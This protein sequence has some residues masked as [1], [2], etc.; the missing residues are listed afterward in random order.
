MKGPK[1]PFHETESGGASFE[2]LCH[3]V[4]PQHRVKAAEKG[5]ADA[6]VPRHKNHRMR[7]ALILSSI[8]ATAWCAASPAKAIG[9]GMTQTPSLLGQPLDFSAQVRV[10]ADEVLSRECVSAEI[11]AGENRLGS[12]QIRVQVASGRDPNE[13]A[14]RVRTLHALNEPIVTINLTVGCTSRVARQFVAFLDPPLLN[15]ARA[16]DANAPQVEPAIR[17][18]ARG[19]RQ[20]AIASQSSADASA[21][22]TVRQRQRSAE[23]RRNAAAMAA[24]PSPSVRVADGA[25]SM[26]K[27]DAQRPAIARSG[28]TARPTGTAR[29]QLESAA[30]AVV[31]AQAASAV[32]TAAAASQQP[33]VQFE[34]EQL[35]LLLAQEKER[36]RSLEASL[37][38]LR[39]EASEANQKR[40]VVAATAPA[41]AATALAIAAPVARPEPQRAASPMLYP[42]VGFGALLAV[43]VGIAAWRPKKKTATR[44]SRWWDLSQQ[45]PPEKGDAVASRVDS[46]GSE[47]EDLRAQLP[48]RV[49]SA[50]AGS[51]VSELTSLPIGG[52]EVTTVAAQAPRSFSA[53]ADTLPAA[54][55]HQRPEAA[56]PS[57]ELLIDLEQEAEFFTVI[58]QDEAAVGL[59]SKHIQREG[60]ISPLPFLKLLEIHRR[61][62]DAAAHDSVAESFRI[63]FSTPPPASNATG[64]GR[65]LDAYPS[66]LAG[67][68]ALWSSPREV[69]PALEAWLFRR[70][71]SAEILDLAAYRDLLF[72]Y[73]VA[74]DRAD[75]GGS[76]DVELDLVLPLDS[77]IDVHLP[78]A[79]ASQ[80]PE[81]R[82]SRSAPLDFDISV[83]ASLDESELRQ[84][85]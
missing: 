57:M 48:P 79:P 10:S 19:D 40:A 73:A 9:F 34:L 44:T 58:G 17:A 72:L 60:P 7:R 74:R 64:G 85:V 82:I 2:E 51:R 4:S 11:Y 12:D 13:R 76:T 56:A 1:D 80:E 21:K 24:R 50:L 53:A 42:L 29:L 6:R 16:E 26:P 31:P 65:S 14:V 46:I 30:A 63:R 81:P 23:R 28:S 54:L 49:A 20:F 83:S 3:D 8:C 43:A 59:L 25:S 35:K 69:M 36:V 38:R 33:A 5:G 62:G 22:P 18:D 84:S 70:G 37:A 61:R 52:L 67:L 77:P 68:Q 32:V 41:V 15:L 75:N 39:N 66:T 47:S 78:I 55:P 45:P 27:H 71:P